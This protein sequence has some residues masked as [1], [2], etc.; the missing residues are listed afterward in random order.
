MNLKPYPG[1]KESG[2]SW[3]G[4][5]P[6]AW[7]VRRGKWLFQNQKELNRDRACKNVLSLTLRGVVNNDPDNPEGLVPKDYATYQLFRKDDFVF[8]LIDLENVRTSRVG[9]VH[10]DGIMSS[11]YVRLFPKNNG[12]IRFFFH[13][14][15]DLYQRA[16]YNQIGAGVRS[17]LAANDLLNVGVLVPPREEQDAI[18]RFLDHAN[19]RIKRGIGAKKKLIALLNEQKQAIIHRAVNRGLDPNTPLKPTGIPSFGDIPKHWE[20]LAL[21]RVLRRLIDCEHKTAPKVDESNMRVVRTTGI[22]HGRLVF[23]GTY[24]TTTKAFKQWTRRGAPEPGDVLFT[25]E[26]PAGEACVVPQD[27]KLCLG[28]RTVLMKLRTER[29]DPHFLVHSIYGGPPRT[30][31]TVA[32]QGSTVG[33]FNMS[34]IAALTIFLPPVPEQVV[35]VNAIRVDTAPLETA[36]ARTEQEI[37]LMQEYRTRLGADVVTGKLDAREAA[38]KLPETRTDSIETLDE[39]AAAEELEPEETGV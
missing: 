16:I 31:I 32:S 21:K 1:Y 10:E 33:H 27:L 5:V 29:L 35:I 15:F 30:A 37:S 17:T 22:R 6:S 34:D 23:R 11:A 26:A 36:I 2:V 19:G 13:Q 20:V 18:V 39:E 7:E 4:K 25:R 14:Y 9:L 8:K 28:Q 38:A 24:G 3:L 12:N